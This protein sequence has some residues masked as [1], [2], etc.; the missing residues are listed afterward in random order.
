MMEK[1]REEGESSES[2]Q[3]SRY[4]VHSWFKKHE[5]DT[6]RPTP[7]TYLSEN[8]KS[9]RMTWAREI[10]KMAG[11]KSRWFVLL[12][13]WF[14]T[15]GRQRRLK[16]LTRVSHEPE[17]IDRV[18][19]PRALSHLF[20]VKV[21]SMG[22]VAQTLPEFDFDRRIFWKGVSYKKVSLSLSPVTVTR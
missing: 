10:E 1:L 21:I 11:D 13:N 18:K 15:T 16:H 8:Q 19:R 17:G 5:G 9:Y 22:V 12:K 3:L 20:P 14:Y 7:I 6:Y 4:Q 2:I